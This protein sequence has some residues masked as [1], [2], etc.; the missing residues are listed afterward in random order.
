MNAARKLTDEE[1]RSKKIRKLKEDTSLG[2][3]VTV[4]RSVTCR[5]RVKLCGVPRVSHVSSPRAGLFRYSAEAT[6]SLDL[7]PKLK[8]LGQKSLN[9]C[10]HHW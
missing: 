4:Y 2:V 8:N 1:K 5:P 10:L 7:M 3:S 9:A 6:P